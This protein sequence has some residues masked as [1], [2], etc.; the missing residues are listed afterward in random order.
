MDGQPVAG[1]IISERLKSE[2]ERKQGKTRFAPV[3]PG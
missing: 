2:P 3:I 1:F